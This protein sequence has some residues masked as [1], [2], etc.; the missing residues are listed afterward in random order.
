MPRKILKLI[1]SWRKYFQWLLFFFSNFLLLM[2]LFYSQHFLLLTVHETIK[3]MLF[4]IYKIFKNYHLG[5]LFSCTTA[6]G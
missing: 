3:L 6:L 4:L 5:K 1:I 2:Y